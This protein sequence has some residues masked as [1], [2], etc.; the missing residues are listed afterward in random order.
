MEAPKTRN[1][2][3]DP[4]TPTG[5]WEQT[6][7]RTNYLL[8]VAIDDYDTRGIPPLKNCVKDAEDLLELLLEEY[9]FDE[10]NVYF[11]C[12]GRA[13]RFSHLVKGEAT[14]RNIIEYMRQVA[15]VCK[16]ENLRRSS[17]QEE[18]A[19]NLLLYYSGHGWY[20]EFLEQGYWI[21]VDATL[22]DFSMYVSNSTIRDFLN[23][24][25]THHT[26]LLADSCFS[27]S[28]FATGEGKSIANTRLE[29][30]PSRWGITAGRN[31]VVS[32]G[33]AGENSPFAANLLEELRKNESIGVQELSFK[34]LEKVAADD[35]QTPRGEP[36]RVRGHK[37]G[38]FVFRKRQN[39]RKHFNIGLQLMDLAEYVP[40][41]SRYLS[42]AKQFEMSV[43]LSRKPEE[44]S[45][46]SLWYARALAAAGAYK[47][48][49]TAL[50]ASPPKV[51][52][53]FLKCCMYYL[54]HKQAEE[55]FSEKIVEAVERFRKDW[56]D[57]IFMPLCAEMEIRMNQSQSVR[58]CLLLVGIDKYQV[59][60]PLNGCVNDLKLI[61]EAFH[62][63]WPDESLL[64]AELSN[65]QATKANI[66]QAFKDLSSQV[67]FEDRFIF[68][69]SGHSTNDGERFLVA[70]DSR[71][72]RGEDISVS[73]L[74][75]AMAQ[76]PPIAKGMILDTDGNRELVKSQKHQI[77][78]YGLFIGSSPHQRAQ[79]TQMGGQP[80]GIFTYSLVEVL[81]QL[82]E[83]DNW[84][85]LPQLVSILMEQRIGNQNPM[86]FNPELVLSQKQ[87]QDIF[88]NLIQ[89]CEGSVRYIKPERVNA[90]LNFL[91]AKD[92]VPD[93][94][95]LLRLAQNANH[96]QK[97]ALFLA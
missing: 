84:E 95:H 64:I 70:H 83:S 91:L 57:H 73:E 54:L 67:V 79:E 32:D 10:E 56:S 33:T 34:V 61:K 75:A 92:I 85:R 62:R 18:A 71:G 77:T 28:L 25:Q 2:F 11:L 60:P 26:L 8:I 12:S 80:H 51:E 86:F 6:L 13:E 7:T 29:Q 42:A 37:G 82:A 1:L 52:H 94:S 88:T 39:A 43:R 69:Y 96:L 21:P 35:K 45:E 72:E 40:E 24:I 81:H 63:I 90:M 3:P 14:R 27:G 9:E 55:D 68:Y 41:R 22:D 53:Q 38:Q 50:E 76:M 30:D 66:L 74:N 58:L 20:D 46:F 87:E 15:Q 44:I 19:A 59:V 4:A 23:G 47:A 5:S 93:Q 16:D 65:E 97:S 36:L 48:A 31:E 89:Y 78:D 49:I 17:Q